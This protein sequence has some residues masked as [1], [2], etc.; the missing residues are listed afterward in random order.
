MKKRVKE[1]DFYFIKEKEREDA[2][3]KRKGEI[4]RFFFY[5]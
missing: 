5:E 4:N 3:F 1:I 2:Y